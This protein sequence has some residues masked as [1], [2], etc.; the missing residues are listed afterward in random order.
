VPAPHITMPF[1]GEDWR[2]P[3]EDWV[4]SEDGW[5]IR[6]VNAMDRG[7]EKKRDG[8]KRR[9]TKT[10]GDR[11]ED[12][13]NAVIRLERHRS[14][15]SL[16]P[17]CPIV[18]KCTREVVGF[19]S[20]ADVLK[21]LDFR[22]AVHDI[23]RFGYVA[24]ILKILVVPDRFYQ[25]SG[26][27]Q[28]FIFRLLEEMA[29]TVYESQTNEHILVKFLADLHSML[30]DKTV[31][32][33]HLGS[34]TLMRRHKN[35][36]TRIACI[37]VLEKRR[38]EIELRKKQ[39]AA[40]TSLE[41]LPEECVREILCKL[42]DYRDVENA[43]RTTPTMKYIVSEKRIWRELVQA[44]F[45]ASEVQFVLNKKP[46][47]KENKN[48]RKLYLELRKNF[49]V[50]AQFSELVMLCKNCRCVFWSSYGHP[51]LSSIAME[52]EESIETPLPLTPTAF[53]SF[54]N[55]ST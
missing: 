50:K 14:L 54:F 45:T 24:A 51:C 8:V 37:T 36:R 55:I 2:G 10:E 31:W 52:P 41:A 26:A 49:G 18:T 11:P 5:E 3:G 35:T 16:Q 19:N 38:N 27:S 40:E 9:R 23:S 30:D 43:G 22:S 20:L 12:R 32:G 4:K 48:S 34:E 39:E 47:L 53:L 29:N 6:K 21:R 17:F 1:I 13:K 28:I 42:S 46:E 44:H 33:S 15:P 7:E 25:L